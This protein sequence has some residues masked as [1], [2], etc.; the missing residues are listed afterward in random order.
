[1]IALT[2]RCLAAI[3]CVFPLFGADL[4]PAGAGMD[5]ERL[6][7][8]PARMQEFVD[9]GTAAGFVTLVA[10]HGKIAALEAVGYQDLASKKPMRTDTIHQIMSCTKPITVAALMMLVDQGRVSL[11]DPAEKYI[12]EF[13][14]ARVN[15]CGVGGAGYHC[16]SRPPKRLVTLVDLATHTSGIASGPASDFPRY[17]SSLEAVVAAGAAQPMQADPGERWSYNNLGI[18][19]LGRVVEV[20]SGQSFESYVAENLFAPLGMRD[21]TFY[22][23]ADKM[24]RVASVYSLEDGKLVPFARNPPRS[25][26]KNPFPEGGL[27]STATDLERFYRMMLAGGVFEGKRAL[28]QAAVDTMTT[29]Q[30]G[31]LPAGWGPGIGFGLGFA[32]V[33]NPIG[34]LRYTAIGSFGH[35]G[36]Y[37]TFTWADPEKDLISIVLYQRSNVGGD[38]AD[39]I[40]AFL[41]MAAA[42]IE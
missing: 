36:A 37:R 24:D 12:P 40:S 18:A 3:L 15:P 32:I 35:G 21:S 1:M 17:T 7:R 39:E 6:A 42:T 23:P 33:K 25:E 27:Y 8:I 19:T 9:Q 22:P 10:R 14:N 4:D 28:S 30:T 29:V 5:P 2:M 41:Q 16:A 11:T 34:A 31:E 26:W 38:M 20:V 13:A